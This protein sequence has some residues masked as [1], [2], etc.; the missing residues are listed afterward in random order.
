[1]ADTWAYGPAGAND[2]A[3]SDRAPATPEA[4][5]VNS[6]DPAVSPQPGGP[7]AAWTW[8][9]IGAGAA[10]VGFL[11][12]LI[13]GLRLPLQNLW[14]TSPLPGDMPIA[15]LPFSQYSVTLVAAIMV[16]GATIAGLIGRTSRARQGRHGFG[17]LTTG[18]LAVQ[19]FAIVQTA[20]VV[21]GGLRLGGES[22]IYLAAIVAAAGASVVV[23][24]LVFGLIARTPPAGALV[25]FSIAAVATGWWLSALLVPNPVVVSE[26]QLALARLTQ[27]VPAV[28]CGVAIAWCGIHTVGRVIAAITAVAAV[29][30]GAAFATGVTSALGTRVLARYPAEMLDYG[31]QVFLQ[32]LGTTGLTVR[33]ILATL[34]VAAVGL[35]FRVVLSHRQ[36]PTPG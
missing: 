13:T 23:G 25:G 19:A 12:W 28:L 2:R 8:L 1:M 18:Y 21:A 29:V 35:V 14:A 30:I 27:W 31:A 9:G 10:A 7:L 16:I 6:A 5:G 32:A 11:P 24:A 26:V 36:A 33:P 22:A 4:A 17:A 34:I 15:L 20:V 3:G